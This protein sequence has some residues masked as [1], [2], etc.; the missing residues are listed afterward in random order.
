MQRFRWQIKLLALIC[1]AI[2]ARDRTSVLAQSANP[3]VGILSGGKSWVPVVAGM[4]EGMERLGFKDHKNI[5]YLAED[6]KGE[7]TDLVSQAK[8]LVDAKADVIFALPTA[9]AEAAMKV[10]T[11]L[12]VVFAWASDPIRSGLIA[13]FAAS[14]NNLTGVTSYS[15][16]LSEK[17]LELLKEIMPSVKRVLAPVSPK[18]I[19]SEVSYQYAEAAAK[20]I[21]LQLIRR[22][23]SSKAEVEKFL[24]EKHKGA[25]DAILFLPSVLLLNQ[26]DQLIA[27]SKEE[28]LP[29]AVTAEDIVERGAL[30]NYGPDFR[31][32]GM[33]SAR[34]L[35]K[36]LKGEK[37]QNIPSEIPEKFLLTLNSRTLKL[38]G[39][40]I[41]QTLAGRIDRLVE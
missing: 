4:K 32:V 3:V 7:I 34:L 5:S 25:V 16:P 31:L 19:A 15:G 39:M 29:L 23:V 11:T 27:K 37:P 38:L 41:P 30:F 33:Q 35:A 2:L 17:R 9:H 36:V 12:P 10:T 8:R 22:E 1:L 6:S 18:E 26:I 14:K 40:K 21:G 13:S 24:A 20:R 28:K